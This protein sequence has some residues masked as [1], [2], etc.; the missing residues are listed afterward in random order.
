MPYEP[1]PCSWVPCVMSRHPPHAVLINQRRKL[2][3]RGWMCLHRS[4]S[5]WVLGPGLRLRACFVS[6]L[7]SHSAVCSQTHTCAWYSLFLLV[8]LWHGP[9]RSHGCVD[10]AGC[11]ASIPASRGP[12]KCVRSWAEEGS[13]DPPPSL[14]LASSFS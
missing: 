8:R 7:G 4:R 10:G 13:Q 3:P 14:S 2:R 5:L 9:W 1:A 6:S 11:L 12:G